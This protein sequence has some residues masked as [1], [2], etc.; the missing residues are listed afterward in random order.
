MEYVEAIAMAQ[1]IKALLEPH[2]YKIEIA[3][4]I[5]RK[6]LQVK[7]IEIVAIPKPY[8]TGLFADGLASVVDLWPCVKG[9]LAYMARSGVK[10]CRY[11]RR[12]YKE[13]V[14]VD[15]FFANPKNWGYILALRTGSTNWNTD[16]LLPS[17]KKA[18]YQALGG[19]IRYQGAVVPVPEETDL[20]KLLRI[21]YILPEGRNI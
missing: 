18:G 12:L 9:E 14:Y 10:Q 21:P 11:T 8:D 15:L 17:I 1:Q 13:G 5:R 20:F 2:C 3:G 16:V 4:S 6:K 7:D 19:H